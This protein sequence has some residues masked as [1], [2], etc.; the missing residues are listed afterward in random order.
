M[1]INSIIS[2]I[3]NSYGTQSV[4]VNSE[5][6]LLQNLKEGIDAL[7]SKGNNAF[8]QGKIISI[9]GGNILLSLGENQLI[10]ATIDGNI[11]ANVGQ[12]MTFGV[13][14]SSNDK[15]SLTPLFENTSQI[16]TVSNALSQANLPNTAQMQ[17]MVKS[18]MD[19]G[20][21]V[22]RD[23]LY[24]MNRAA[25]KFPDADVLD[26]VRMNK[27]GIPLTDENIQQ[28]QNYS[29]YEHQ[30]TNA[31]SDI[32]ES[33]LQSAAEWVKTSGFA[34]G[35]N[36]FD[37]ILGNLLKDIGN[38]EEA[39]LVN[40]EI[41]NSRSESVDAGI[42]NKEGVALQAEDKALINV[43]NNLEEANNNENV[44]PLK[45]EFLQEL[46]N[47][48]LDENVINKFQNNELLTDKDIQKVIT[49]LKNMPG[50]SENA[51][52]ADDLFENPIFKDSIKK[53]VTDKYLLTPDEI[54]KEGKVNSLYEKIQENM[55]AVLDNMQSLGK[56]DS[57]LFNNVNNLNNNLDFMNQLNQAFT[58]VQIPLQLSNQNA[59]GDLYVYTNKK[60]LAQKDGDV[61]ALLHL[62]MD[63][64]GSVDVHVALTSSN[65]VKTKFYLK[66]ESA[67]ELIA[68]NIHTLNERLEKRGYNMNAE[69]INKDDNKTVIDTMLES[70]GNISGVYSGSFDARA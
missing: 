6:E 12:M 67:L 63:N 51:K 54:S 36:T 10:N 65:N 20:L 8:I 1:N 4:N 70:K 29:N 24:G 48:G 69:F 66:D 25:V 26:L 68:A 32:S 64:L 42:E 39:E 38:P 55:K 58:Y 15:I 61:S 33:L 9:E 57:P 17:Y 22:D 5:G 27:L 7:I 45:Y 23:S 13:N 49:S 30:I 37:D 52:T 46:K 21:P 47:S 16:S 19:E 59:N 28:F 31:F 41:L 35:I 62:D 44:K 3:N 50:S 40:E 11:N 56:T 60:S 53:V 18:M 2:Q 34:E 14:M 43:S